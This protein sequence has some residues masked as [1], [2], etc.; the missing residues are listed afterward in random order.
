[1]QPVQFDQISDE[2]ITI[3][4]DDDHESIY[5]ASHLRKNCPCAVCSGEKEPKSESPFKILKTGL[6]ELKITG[7]EL[8]GRY[9]VNFQFSDGHKTGIYTYEHLRN[10][11]QCDLCADDV[12]R[13]QGPFK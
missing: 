12:I 11:C 4:W 8:V 10:L 9:A 3:K 6:D 7:W 13:L 1:M 5:F 2:V